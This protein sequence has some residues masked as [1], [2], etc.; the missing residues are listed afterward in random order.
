MLYLVSCLLCLF[1]FCY[2]LIVACCVLPFV[3]GCSLLVVVVMCC[4]LCCVVCCLVLGV[5]CFELGV[6]G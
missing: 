5:C 2:S 4:C 3:D 1:V 6:R